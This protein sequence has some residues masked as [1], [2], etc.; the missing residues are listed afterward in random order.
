MNKIDEAVILLGGMGTRMLP[1]TKTVSKEML[2]IY[3]VPNIYLLVK[4]CYLSGIKKIIFVITK[5]NKNLIQSFFTRDNYLDN[6]LKD[7]PDKQILLKDINEIINNMTFKYVYQEIKGTY[8]ALYSARKYIKN[9]NFIVL[10]GDDLIDSEKPIIKEMINEYQSN[11]NMYVLLKKEETSLLP[12]SGLPLLD[13]NNYITKFVK[14]D[15]VN[16]NCYIIGRMLLNKKIFTIKNKL[17]Y[18]DN[19]E[20]YLPHALLNFNDLKGYFSDY[21]YFNIGE[22][23]GFIKASIHYAMKDNNVKNDLLNFINTLK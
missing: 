5:H 21:N 18:Y 20:L 13:S 2:P 1:Y 8:G 11:P 17:K 10:Y 4:E 15:E 12:K 19:Q 14:K 16:S 23:I 7:K 3:D 6:F 9:D 22:K